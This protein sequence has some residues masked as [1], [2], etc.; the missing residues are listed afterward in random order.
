V[1]ITF[2]TTIYKSGM[3]NAAGIV[4]PE[5]KLLAHDGGKRPAVTVAL[6]NHTY[7]STVGKM[8]DIYLIPL[9]AEHRNASGLHGGE[10]I[11]ITLALDTEP[12]VTPIPDDLKAA[13]S[14]HSLLDSFS[15]LSPS[16]IKEFVRQVEEAKSAETRARRIA[17]VV[18]DSKG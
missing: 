14:E 16:R 9:S 10:T 12:R 4:I 5:D 1:S 13:L 18:E 17:K 7:R 6:P 2:T 8:G 11:E 3:K 15:K